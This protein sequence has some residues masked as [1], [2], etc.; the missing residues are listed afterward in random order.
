MDLG[1]GSA[2]STW[3][4]I[5]RIVARKFADDQIPGRAAQMS[6]YFFLSIF[7]ILLIVVAILGLVLDVQWLVADTIISRLAALAPPSIARLFTELLDQLARQPG[8]PLTWGI[9]VTL[10]AAS[11][12]MVATIH[13]LNQAYAVEEE[14]PW[15]RRRLVGL[16]LTLV[17]M[18]I[19]TAA[20]LLL[21]YGVPLAQAFAK[22]LGFHS[23]SLLAWRIAQWPVIF[24]FVLVAFH[25]LYYFAPSRPLGRW[26][27]FRAGT[28]IAIALWF[29]A[30]LGLKFYIANFANY[31]VAYGSLGAIIVLLLWFYLT[32]IAILT[33]AEINA[34][35]ERRKPR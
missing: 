26:V 14:R 3:T 34:Q 18:L 28:L 27:W 30:S 10:W 13:G 16:T 31:N 1:N 23:A 11:S 9:L 22:R 21:A 32:S 5:L 7:P 19:I 20:M 12:G 29:A 25:L 33:G 35:C 4:E 8:K 17:F 24:A 2:A 6:F 15:W